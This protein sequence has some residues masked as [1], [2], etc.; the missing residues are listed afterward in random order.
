[1]RGY[2]LKDLA[3]D[4]NFAN[5]LKAKPAAEQ[6]GLVGAWESA[7]SRNIDEAI[8]RNPDFLEML[9]KFPFGTGKKKLLDDATDADWTQIF[10]GKLVDV[11]DPDP[12][13]AE[14]VNRFGGRSGVKFDTDP[15]GK[16]FDL[17]SETLIGEHKML[18]S[19]SPINSGD[20]YSYRI[21]MIAAKKHGKEAVWVFEGVQNDSHIN[22][23]IQ[24]ANEYQVN[25][26]IELNGVVIHNLTF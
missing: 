14:L 11:P 3:D 26:V 21:Q 19:T 6:A 7:L 13:A 8:R 5:A 2:L 24:Y 22:K 17:V 15:S 4:V 20:R 9:N 18:N 1:L 23:V 25:T 10:S 12:N 16:E